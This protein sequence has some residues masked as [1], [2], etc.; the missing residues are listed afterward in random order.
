MRALPGRI[1]PHF[2]PGEAAGSHDQ[3]SGKATC[4]HPRPRGREGRGKE[5][6]TST[7]AEPLGGADIPPQASSREH[8]KKKTDLHAMMELL[9]GKQ[10]SLVGM[11]KRVMALD[12]PPTASTIA[13][14]A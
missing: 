5:K 10:A 6:K 11:P 1:G 9:E 13:R 14:L 2:W 4:A 12:G 3:R 7:K 8:K